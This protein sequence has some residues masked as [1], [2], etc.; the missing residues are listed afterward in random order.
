MLTVPLKEV[1]EFVR[2]NYKICGDF[3]AES[4]GISVGGVGSPDGWSTIVSRTNRGQEFLRH[5]RRMVG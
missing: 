5:T 3:T 2:S 4:A 1:K